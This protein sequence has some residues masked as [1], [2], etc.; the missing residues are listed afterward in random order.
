MRVEGVGI[1][2]IKEE[3]MKWP[4]SRFFQQTL[5]TIVC[6]FAGIGLL[7]VSVW[8]TGGPTQ[9][10]N[11]MS[12]Q[13]RARMRASVKE[14]RENV[15][16]EDLKVINKTRKF[17]VVNIEQ[18]NGQSL[19]LQLT[20]KNG[21]KKGITAF[22]YGVGGLGQRTSPELATSEK[23]SESRIPPGG[24]TTEYSGL[25]LTNIHQLPDGSI[26]I[27][28]EENLFIIVYAVIFDDKTAEGDPEIIAEMR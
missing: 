22:S 2:A 21:Y 24:T 14:F 25:S 20:L 5:F 17:E 27:P 28:K 13:A 19:T 1:P 8:S 12:P 10:Q 9:N 15:K 3:P 6:Q 18:G 26:S 4:R 23:D 16:V 11:P 7:T